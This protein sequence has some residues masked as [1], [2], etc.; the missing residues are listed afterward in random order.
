MGAGAGAEGDGIVEVGK[1]GAEEMATATIHSIPDRIIMGLRHTA[2]SVVDQ[3][4]GDTPE[5]EEG[6]ILIETTGLSSPTHINL[7]LSISHNHRPIITA[8]LE[9]TQ[10][11]EDMGATE[12]MPRVATVQGD[13]IPIMPTAETDIRLRHHRKTATALMAMMARVDMEDTEV[14]EA[15]LLTLC[16]TQGEELIIMLTLVAVEGEVGEVLALSEPYS[17]SFNINVSM[18]SSSKKARYL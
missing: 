3:V 1:E 12:R 10:V 8:T 17:L 6:V 9:D 11:A 7:D 13:T 2:M 14:M 18:I 16:I 5:P 4:I 15:Y